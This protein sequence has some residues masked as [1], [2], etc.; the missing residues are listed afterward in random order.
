MRQL[1]PQSYYYPKYVK[2][3]GLVIL[4]SMQVDSGSAAMAENPSQQGT[5]QS[6]SQPQDEAV[7]IQKIQELLKTKNDTPR[8]VGLALLK[9]VLDNSQQLR[10]D[11]AT[12]TSLWHSVSPKFLDRL[13]RSGSKQS[14]SS[15]DAKDMTEIAVAVLHTFSILLP[16]DVKKE[17]RIISRIPSLVSVVLHRYIA[18]VQC[19][20]TGE[21]ELNRLN[22]SDNTIQLVLQTLLALVS[23]PE[24]AKVFLGVNDVSSLVE[25]APAQPLALDIFLYA[26]VQSSV[27]QEDKQSLRSA[28]DQTI[29]T[30]A[31]SFKGTDAVTILNFVDHLLR[32]LD[33]EVRVPKSLEHTEHSHQQTGRPFRRVQTG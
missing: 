7:T 23:S 2:Y 24:G 21:W 16:A 19:V 3:P 14:S 22:S 20:F 4:S 28:V 13:L 25:M 5:D 10:E 30:L 29:Q 26:F 1:S 6:Q 18:S 32:R 33:P 11:E 8:F 9:S 27:S 17:S 15:K 31:V 12:I